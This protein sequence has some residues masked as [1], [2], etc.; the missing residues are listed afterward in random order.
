MLVVT[1]ILLPH[2][3]NT[4]SAHRDDTT[5]YIHSNIDQLDITSEYHGGSEPAPKSKSIST[6]M[7]IT[8]AVIA[9]L[10]IA[11]A[12]ITAG[13]LL[14]RE[15]E[16]ISSKTTPAPIGEG[17]ATNNESSVTFCLPSVAY[18]VC[19]NA[20]CME[21][22]DCECNA[23]AKDSLDDALVGNCVACNVTGN[24]QW[25]I[26]CTNLKG[27]EYIDASQSALK[28][29]E[30]IDASQSPTAIP[31]SSSMPSSEDAP[32]SVPS[33]TPTVKTQQLSDG[34]SV[35][36]A[37]KCDPNEESSE[38]SNDAV[39]ETVRKF[40]ETGLRNP[41]IFGLKTRIARAVCGSQQVSRHLGDNLD[42]DK[43]AK[44]HRHLPV[45][46]SAL[47]YSVVITGEYR[48]PSRPGKF[49]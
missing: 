16:L 29:K 7:Q 48:P 43:A 18:H 14:T 34:L 37:I 44:K 28:G 49:L 26:D 41:F 21:S 25:K 22:A 8:L 42:H 13:V 31:T 20:T 23:Y 46:S 38:Q 10:I 12:S 45:S 30:C 39:A 33:I 1:I 17:A 15:D 4:T 2:I 3:N 47:D 9:V 32:S 40:V 35:K 11:A 27:K 5:Q 6:R 24:H 36:F 19:M